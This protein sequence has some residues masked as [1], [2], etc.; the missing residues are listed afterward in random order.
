ML[1]TFE[2]PGRFWKGNLHAHSDRSDGAI[3]PSAVFGKYRAAGYDFIALTDHYLERFGFPIFDG[4]AESHDRFTILPGAEL[5]APANSRGDDWHI[6]AVGLPLDFAPTAAEE[7]GAQLARRAKAAGAFI[8]IPHPHWSQLTLADVEALDF[9]H[10]IEVYNHTSFVNCDRG[11]GLVLYDSALIA[12]HRMGAIATDDAHFHVEDAHGGWIMAKAASNAPDD[13]LQALRDGHYYASQGPVF[14]DIRREND[15]LLL[16][17]SP[18][19]SLMLSG[20]GTGS[21]RCH[22]TDIT[23]ARLPLDGFP[24]WCRATAI[25]HMGC[26]AWTGPLELE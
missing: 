3:A 2:A 6:L 22:G 12:G 25:D 18:V 20:P 16:T 24:D 15:A 5:H 8:A 11:D 26:R 14:E 21:V 17:S 7:T 10:A 1:A 19:R 4:R 9:A 23:H 13:L